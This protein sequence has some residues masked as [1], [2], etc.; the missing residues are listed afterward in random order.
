M[1]RFAFW[2][3]GRG[4]YLAATDAVR[5]RIGQRRFVVTGEQVLRAYQTWCRAV[6]AE[7]EKAAAHRKPRR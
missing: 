2:L 5:A 6:V 7:R 3:V 1:T 4:A